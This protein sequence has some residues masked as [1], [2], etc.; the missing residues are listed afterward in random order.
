MFLGKKSGCV[1]IHWECAEVNPSK[2]RK[3]S[4]PWFLTQQLGPG[5]GDERR[6]HTQSTVQDRTG[7]LNPCGDPGGISYVED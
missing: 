2:P 4:L 3:G 7:G 6:A 5:A 1:G